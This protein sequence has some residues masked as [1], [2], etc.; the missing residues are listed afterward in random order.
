M[1]QD[2]FLKINGIAGEARD[3]IHAGEIE[4]LRWRWVVSQPSNM[5]IGCGG[6]IGKCSVEDLEFDHNIDKA[7]PNLLQHCLSGRPL[8]EAV[9]TMRKAGG[10]ALDYLCLTLQQVIITRVQP[11]HHYSMPAAC[12]KVCLSF[13]RVKMAYVLQNAHGS[14]AGAVATGYDTKANAVI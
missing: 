6:G 2:I 3:A 5:P 4:V 9:L 1:A 10:V 12:E 8:P 14:T 7:S 11:V 13:A